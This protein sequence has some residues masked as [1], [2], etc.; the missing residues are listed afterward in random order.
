V[1][2]RTPEIA[3]LKAI[4][5]SDRAVLGFILSESLVIAVLGCIGLLLALLA[6]PVLSRAMAGLL[7]ALLISPK[8]LISGVAAALAVGFASAILPGLGA[9]RMRVVD[10]LRRV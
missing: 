1:R 4:G 10:A 8:V 2:E 9:M 6:V 3:I 5:F 7:P